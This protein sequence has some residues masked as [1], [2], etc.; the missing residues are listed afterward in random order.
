MA[1]NLIVAF[2]TLCIGGFVAAW[3][4][5]PRLRALCERPKERFLRTVQTSQKVEKTSEIA[6]E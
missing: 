1:I 4:R 5:S 2:V 3:A 6:E